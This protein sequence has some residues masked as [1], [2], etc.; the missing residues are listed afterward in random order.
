MRLLS[1]FLLLASMAALAGP[2]PAQPLFVPL[3]VDDGLPSNV[4]YKTVQDHDGFVWIGTQDGLAR[5]DSIG[6]RVFRHDPADS[7]SLTSNDVSA[8]L[9]DR[10]GTLWCG[11]EGNGLNRLNADG[12]SFAHWLHRPNDLGT[13]GSS[14]V[15]SIAQ[16][17]GGSIWVGTY[18]GGLNRLQDDG[19]FLHVDHDPEDPRSLRSNTVYALHA[20]AHNRLWI[21]TDE[22][23]D[24]READGRIVHVELPPLTERPGRS[25]VM[26]FLPDDNDGVLVATYKGLFRVDAQLR[27][28]GELL[29]SQP[30]LRVSA[31]ARGH[32][33]GLWVGS[34]AGLARLDERGVQRYGTAEAAPGGY[35]GSRTMDIRTDAEG[36]TWFA[37]FD[38]GVARLPPHWRNFAVFRHVPGDTTSLVRQRV[39]AVAIEG[40]RAVWVVSGRDGLDRI[41]QESGHIDHWGE[42]LGL[43]SE[44]PYALLP[45]GSGHIW[46]G[47][48]SG[49]RHYSL[50]TGEVT[51]LAADL[52]RADALPQGYV[53]RLF[54]VPDGTVWASVRGGGA[55]HVASDPPRV[56]RRYMPATRSLG[57][58]DIVDM[59]L[60]LDA[61]PWVATAS[62]VERYDPER[63]RFTGVAG[64]PGESVHAL[65]FAPDGK[66]WL[67]R[68]GALERYRIDGNLAQLERRYDA[69]SGWPA[70]TAA[71]LAVADDDS[72]WV[73]SLRGLW[74]IDDRTRTIRHFD[75]R[76]G[77]PSLEFQPRA[78]ASAPDG[79]L[80]AGTAAGV[81]AFDPALMRFDAPPPPVRLTA[82]SVRRA[83]RVEAL[84]MGLPV[85]LRHDDVD[86]RIE[87]RAL[88]FANPAA[89]RYQFQLAPFD[90]GWIDAEHGER[91]Y[92]QLV[93]G[94]YRLRVRAA[95]AD[96]VWSELSSPWRCRLRTRH[97]RRRLPMRRT[98]W[99]RCSR[100]GRC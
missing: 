35:P 52:S 94:D 10:D 1:L 89:N 5:Y 96:G 55:V 12:R 50:A 62:G 19:S 85:Q 71:A 40:T 39:N 37:L 99:P 47:S 6:F 18:L 45:D 58:A 24:V 51:R 36:G 2:P 7:T 65:A 90:R 29:A 60:D 38:G 75:A 48:H 97:G 98:R 95:N 26:S 72:V 79:T 81:V 66:L 73:T 34:N 83:G 25:V 56:L 67:H 70:Q 87:A 33:K 84:E 13:L 27:Y 43:G 9:V 63:D 61:R 74:R 32:D 86:F 64:L 92:S 30:V 22:G 68:L 53:N 4:V 91:V 16:D 15:F 46:V 41:D 11:G 49:L 44:Q 8:L 82:L 59:A 17:A 42:R 76:D 78:L 21:G 23:L 88:S 57:D 14:D 54:A 80:Y 31:L 28:L 77:L 100:P 3:G 93:A 69:G 20:D